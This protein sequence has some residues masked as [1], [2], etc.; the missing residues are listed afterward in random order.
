MNC[1][2]FRERMTAF[3]A[4]ELADD[5]RAALQAHLNGCSDCGRRLEIEESLLRGIRARLSR[6]PVPPGLETRIRASLA[7]EAAPRRAGAW[8]LRPWLAATA[9][10]ALLV[11]LL[12]P[13]LGEPLEPLPGSGER[14]VV[15]GQVVVVVDR[16]CDSAGRSL[17]QQRHCKHRLHVNALKLPDGKYWNLSTGQTDGREII[18]DR[19]MRGRRLAVDGDLFPLIRTLW[20]TGVQTSPAGSDTL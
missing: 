3:Q 19:G 9:A 15:R 17:E 7:A 14:Q 20:L 6:Q 12:L 13:G 1:A 16:Q 5:E 4:D 8:F 2:G 11:L 10:A 18:L